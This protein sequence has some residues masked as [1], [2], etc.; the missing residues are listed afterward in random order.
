M[1]KFFC[2]P[3]KRELQ[4]VEHLASVDRAL[5]TK[6]FADMLRVHVRTAGRH[7]VVA[8]A[9]CRIPGRAGIVW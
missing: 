1:K 6:Q 3:G 8:G 7:G 5:T 4:A 2:L 9:S